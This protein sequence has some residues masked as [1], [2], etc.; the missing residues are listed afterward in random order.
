MVIVIG[1]LFLV[2]FVLLVVFDCL[3]CFIPCMILLHL[4]GLCLPWRVKAFSICHLCI[5]L[6]S[7][8]RR[9]GVEKA[10]IH[11]YKNV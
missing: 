9:F 3:E 4:I 10:K 2:I 1:L 5:L 8:M 11:I 6:H 7:C